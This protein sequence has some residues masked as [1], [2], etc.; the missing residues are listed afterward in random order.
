MGIVCE[1]REDAILAGRQVLF[2][3]FKADVTGV[4]QTFIVSLFD[5]DEQFFGVKIG[6]INK[7]IARSWPPGITGAI[8]EFRGRARKAP[9]EMRSEPPDRKSPGSKHRS[10]LLEQP[11]GYRQN[12]LLLVGA[13]VGIDRPANH[14]IRKLLRNRMIVQRRTVITPQFESRFTGCPDEIARVDGFRQPH[15][16]G[17]PRRVSCVASASAASV[18]LEEVVISSD[19]GA[20]DAE[21]LIESI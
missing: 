19:P 3:M 5:I 20:A 11:L 17:L 14:P 7:R 2:D 15:G 1:S 13:H 12:A 6:A 8:S 4:N 18:V 16:K 21:E 9:V 10:K